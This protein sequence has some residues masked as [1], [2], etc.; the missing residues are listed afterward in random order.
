MDG[1]IGVGLPCI[2]TWYPGHHELLWI[3]YC[4]SP[5]QVSRTHVFQRPSQT[6]STSRNENTM[7]RSAKYNHTWKNI[8]AI[9]NQCLLS[10]SS[11]GI[12]LRLTVR[13]W[14]MIKCEKKKILQP[15]YSTDV[16]YVLI[17]SSIKTSFVFLFYFV[18]HIEM[19]CLF[20]GGLWRN[21]FYNVIILFCFVLHM[22]FLYVGGHWENCF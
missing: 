14:Q 2:G 4:T 10:C 12:K 15:L 9:F 5:Q 22:T 11:M 3:L 20:V 16:K 13:A 21:L 1:G 17:L 8:R 7:N 6:T 18:L 19:K